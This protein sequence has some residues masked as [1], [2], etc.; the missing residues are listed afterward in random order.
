[1]RIWRIL[2]L[3]LAFKF[4]HGNLL[5]YSGGRQTFTLVAYAPGCWDFIPT[6]IAVDTSTGTLIVTACD[7]IYRMTTLGV[8]THIAGEY[9]CNNM[10]AE[11]VDA[12]SACFNKPVVAVDL[13]G[14][15]YILSKFHHTVRKFTVAT[16]I[17]T[18]LAGSNVTQGGRLKEG[19][20]GYADGSGT[21]ARFTYPDALA[22][23]A[24]GNIF[25]AES[26]THRIRKVTPEGVV[27]TIAGSGVGGYAEG[28]GTNAAFNVP[29]SIA[30]H[31]SGNIYVADLWNYR[32]RKVTPAGVVTTLAGSGAPYVPPWVQGDYESTYT[33][34]GTGTNASF[35]YPRAVAVDTDQNVYVADQYSDVIRMVSPGGVVTTVAG[36]ARNVPDN[37]DGVGVLAQIKSP[38]GIAFASSTNTL[39]VF[40]EQGLDN[41]WRLI[42]GLVWPSPPPPSPPPSPPPP[43]PPPSPSPPPPSPLFCLQSQSSHLMT[44]SVPCV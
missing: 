26:Y 20:S 16:G 17:V 25:V 7:M 2:F 3:T 5:T 1:M 34:E 40:Q 22:I 38:W 4:G 6:S 33:Y 8:V 21:Q 24:A 18:L 14:N 9:S 36:G 42:R 27:T 19:T 28:T 13:S 43:N 44:Q 15:I 12:L 31:S 37:S 32:I 39:Y 10:Q 30:V 41:S 35:S 11:P 29:I 23:D